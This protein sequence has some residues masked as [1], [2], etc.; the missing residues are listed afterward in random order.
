MN[1]RYLT[2]YSVTILLGHV[3]KC[4]E[5]RRPAGTNPSE[6]LLVVM[7]SE[8]GETPA[9]PGNSSD[10]MLDFFRHRFLTVKPTRI[11]D[12]HAEKLAEHMNGG[13]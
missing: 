1:L 13:R 4:W 12:A 8:A 5:R 6:P 3:G 11:V 2:V 7:H 9:L 10:L